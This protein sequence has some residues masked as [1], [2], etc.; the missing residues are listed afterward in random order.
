[1]QGHLA[2]VKYLLQ[3]ELNTERLLADRKVTFPAFRLVP[4]Y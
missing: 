4:Y 2:V 1:M 3:Q